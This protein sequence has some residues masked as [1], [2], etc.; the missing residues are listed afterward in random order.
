MIETEVKKSE[1]LPSFE[2]G[3]RNDLTPSEDVLRRLGEYLVMRFRKLKTFRTNCGW[4]KEKADALLSYHMEPKTRTLPFPGASNLS[5]PLSRI[6]VDSFHSNVMGSLFATGNRLIVKPVIISKDFANTAQKA[7]DYMTFVMNNEADSYVVIDDADKKANLFGNGYLEPSYVKE[8]IWETVEI[9][10]TTEVPTVDPITREVTF[11]E[12]TKKVTKKKKRTD[13][14]GIKIQSLPVESIYKSPFIGTI[15]QA[16]KEDVVF[17][18]FNQS[19][20]DIKD[21][22]KKQ[23]DRPSFY[24]D[25]QV[26]K[27]EP[28]V[29]DKIRKSLSDLDNAR[30][31]V[32]G[33]FL[34][35]LSQE[36]Q[37]DLAEAH[38]WYDIDGDGIKEE[39]SA[40]F[41]QELGHVIRV[42][43]SKCRI[44]E[45]V[46]RPMDG[47]GYGEGI[48]RICRELD[49]EWENFHNTRAN[50]GQWENTTFGFY[51]AG[52]R[53]NPQ[54]ITIRPGHF[55]PVDDPREISFPN[56][57]RVGQ[58]FFQEEGLILNYFERIFALDENIQGVSSQKAQTATETMRV[59]SKASVRFA[60][61]FNRIVTSINELLQHVWEL[62]A[63]CAPPMKE[64]YV[65]GEDGTQIFDKMSKYDFSSKLKF[66][67]EVSSIFDQQMIRDTMLLTYRL[68]ITNPV[69]MQHPEVLYRLSQQ[70]LDSMNVNLKMP[71]PPQ[72]NTLSPFEEH[73][74]FK[75]GEDAEPEP[76]EDTKYHYKVHMGQLNDPTIKDWDT[77]AVKRL[78]LHIDKTKILE[79]TLQSANLNQ[80]GMFTGNP[81]PSQPGMTASRN[82]AQMF[83]TTRIGE[84]GKSATQNLKNGQGG[85]PNVEQDQNNIFGNTIS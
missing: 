13:F 72:A 12:E 84:S 27:I 45:I 20:S 82:P 39:I 38:L 18:V 49:M 8:E 53:L 62:N 79:Q 6:G 64:F 29:V 67:V 51:R 2:V 47:R 4:E 66:S 60:N 46:P 42:T 7:A 5:S 48:P 61:P 9:S 43:L 50:A 25:S 56:I 10:E 65:V 44:V 33:F 28:V 37:V 71:K 17:K 32:D 35:M 81:M 15:K 70:T 73:E 76:G 63:D 74:M 80:S 83:N 57:P 58:S 31:Q 1:A 16:V 23:P 52:G 26:K 75:H 24:I 11:K 55:Y 22:S 34:D 59:S 21:R 3:S 41:H 54:T 14:D 68:F 85:Q 77:D 36:E 69:A 19:F 40:V 30:A 78:V